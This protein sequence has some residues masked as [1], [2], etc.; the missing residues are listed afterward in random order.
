[1]SESSALASYIDLL[2]ACFPILRVQRSILL[3]EGWDSVALLINDE[4]VFRFAKRPDA[5][6]RQAR[7]NELLPLL[8][9]RLP[10]PIPRYTHTWTDPTWPGKRIVGYRLIAGEPLTHSRPEHRATQAAQLGAFVSALHA[11]PLEEAQ[12]HGVVGRDAASL[13]E[14]HRRFFATVRANMLP[15]FTAQEQAAIVALWSR[16]LQD[17]TCFTFTPTL[18]HRDLDTEHVLG[19]PVTGDLTGV[20][21]WGDA[22][23][24]DPAVDFAG[25]R[26]QLGEDFSRQMLAAYRHSLDATVLRRMDFYAGME[27]FHEIHFGQMHGDTA[28]LTHGVE[29]ARRLCAQA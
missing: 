2:Q 1:M 10:V 24:D 21:D 15:L 6:V 14:A 17:D 20:I 23:I 25:V 13:R 7:E 12:R 26:R 18:V 29:S 11:V 4:H 19:D 9:D 3:G 22:G 8:A 28:H 5:A 16:Y 27:P